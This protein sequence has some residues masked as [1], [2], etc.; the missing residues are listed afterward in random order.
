MGRI[1]YRGPRAFL[2]EGLGGMG[3]G[4]RLSQQSF[5]RTG[6]EGDEPGR[7]YINKCQVRPSLANSLLKERTGKTGDLSLARHLKSL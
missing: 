6:L 5:L 4:T 7:R 1:H 3:M 2:E